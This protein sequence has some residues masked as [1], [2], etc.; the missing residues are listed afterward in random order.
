MGLLGVLPREHL[1]RPLEALA[2]LGG[3]PRH[4]EVVMEP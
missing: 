4:I 3:H 1:V 2:T